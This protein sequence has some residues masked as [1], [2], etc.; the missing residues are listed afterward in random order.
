MGKRLVPCRR[1]RH[2]R[3]RSAAGD[4]QGVDAPEVDTPQGE[5]GM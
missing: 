4:E 1:S 3:R 2:F 5:L